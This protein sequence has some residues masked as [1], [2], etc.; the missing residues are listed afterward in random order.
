MRGWF[1][2]RERAP[3]GID[4]TALVNFERRIDAF[5]L[6]LVLVMH[7]TSGLP[8]H[9]P[10]L[11]SL[12]YGNTAMSMRNC[13]F[14]L[15]RLVT[16]TEWNALSAARRIIASFLPNAMARLYVA[17]VAEALPYRC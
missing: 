10:E 8:A 14:I 4:A 15:G 16:V 5:L 17:Y 1:R 2:V 7:L 3:R 11:M 13:V 6:K 12:K 9:G